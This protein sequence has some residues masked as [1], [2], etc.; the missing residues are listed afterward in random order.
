MALCA[1][2]INVLGDCG[3]KL[4][5]GSVFLMCYLIHRQSV[6][7]I[8][9]GNN[10]RTHS[11]RIT[12]SDPQQKKNTFAYKAGFG[13]DGQLAHLGVLMFLSM[14]K[15]L[16]IENVSWCASG[17]TAATTATTA[18]RL[19]LAGRTYKLVFMCAQR[20]RETVGMWCYGRR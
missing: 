1:C 18:E 3:H 8:S 6:Y 16:F 20:Q 5:R 19:A 9:Y 17:P 13:T 11:K 15:T 7:V 4:Q 10:P 12:N 2:R 14:H